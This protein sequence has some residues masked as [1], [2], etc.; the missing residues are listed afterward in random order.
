MATSERHCHTPA[1]TLPARH[2]DARNSDAGLRVAFGTS[3]ARRQRVAVWI[4][5]SASASSPDPQSWTDPEKRRSIGHTHSGLCTARRMLA[6]F[7]QAGAS[8]SVGVDPSA[9]RACVDAALAPAVRAVAEPLLVHS[10]KVS[11]FAVLVSASDSDNTFT[12][13]CRNTGTPLWSSRVHSQHS[14]NEIEDQDFWFPSHLLDEA[15]DCVCVVDCDS[16]S[17]AESVTAIARTLSPVPSEGS[18]IS[19][20]SIS[21]LDSIG[22]VDRE[23]ENATLRPPKDAGFSCTS[24]IPPPLFSDSSESASLS[25]VGAGPGTPALLT[26]AAISAIQSCSLLI[27]DRL[28]PADLIKYA[29]TVQITPQS[30]SSAPKSSKTILSQVAYDKTKPST[31]RRI[32]PYILH[33]RKV[34]G[35]AP[36]TQKE[37]E[38]WTAAAL[39]LGHSVV[40]LKGGDPFVYGRGGEEYIS[41]AQATQ[42]NN[43]P[44]KINV[45]PGLSSSLVA[46][47]MAGIPATHRGL[48]DQILIAT[49]RLEEEHKDVE[50]PTYAPNRTTVV[51]MAMGRIQRCVRGM[52]EEAG[53]P[54]DVPVAIVEKA[55]WGR[56]NGERVW[57]GV[58]GNVADAVKTLGMKAHATLVIGRVVHALE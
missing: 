40:R 16:D 9:T 50:W 43:A 11:N 14:D 55:G 47:L 22:D 45:V 36:E 29:L 6:A 37:I 3:A 2:R 51:L 32:M 12:R 17:E 34:L 20:D 56:D 46:P 8:I 4:D 39:S 27:V 19:E 57:K 15:A 38:D 35:N 44:I 41:A 24:F 42:E 30:A 10:Q 53:Y 1:R 21:F 48:S 33:T 52:V 7:A 26:V 28:V 25:I 54:L 58:L 23:I 5:S 18:L 13:I 31:M 49:G